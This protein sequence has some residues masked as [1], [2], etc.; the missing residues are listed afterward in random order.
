MIPPS[1]AASLQLAD[2]RPKNIEPPLR[3]EY[4][5]TTRIL[6]PLHL[7]PTRVWA[8]AEGNFVIALNKNS[9]AG[10]VAVEV[11]DRLSSPIPALPAA[12]G[13]LTQFVPLGNGTM[14]AVDGASGNLC[15]RAER[16][17]AGR[18]RRYQ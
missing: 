12:I 7:T 11:D 14:I 1:V 3:W 2:L 9:Q 15:R 13:D 6:Y 4:G 8:F 16:P 18:R 5:L 17:V 10:K